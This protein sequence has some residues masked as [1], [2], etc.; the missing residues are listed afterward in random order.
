M[1]DGRRLWKHA[2][3]VAMVATVIVL[4]CYAMC[5]FGLRVFIGHR[6]TLQ[7]DQRIHAALSRSA[8]EPLRPVS[9]SPGGASSNGD[10][11][12]APVVLWYV[13][14]HGAVVNLTA[15]APILPHRR[16]SNIPVTM[17]IGATAFRFAAVRRDHG[18]VVAGQ[19]VSEVQRVDTALVLPEVLFGLLLCLATFVGSLLVAY[20]ASVP[21]ELVRRRQAEF[22]ADASHELR[23]PLSVVEAEVDLALRKPR[24]PEEYE[25]VLHRIAGESARLRRLVDDLLWLARAD[26]ITDG[27]RD[28]ETSDVA[29]VVASCVDRF[30]VVA[31]RDDLTLTFHSEGAGS[32]LVQASAELV[33]RLA[34]VLI[35]NAC[36]Y[37][38][39]GGAVSVTV[40]SR[41]GRV[42]LRVDDSGPG[43]P[44]QQRAAVFNRFHRIAPGGSG[45]GLGL[46]IADSVV[47]ITKGMWTLDEAPL[48]GARMEVSWP[49]LHLAGPPTDAGD[50]PPDT[51]QE[52]ARRPSTSAL[53]S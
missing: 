21:V 13:P 33:D 42:V 50:R 49:A 35:D 32:G 27:D 30:E 11:D 43:I 8:G 29:V 38:G 24:T 53:R 34:G 12:D 20:R 37:A 51:P 3:R 10:L 52:R 41:T 18:W 5:G 4:G 14:D 15:S 19:N 28:A 16:W 31:T 7:A 48:G 23:T 6:L 40:E 36:K 39:S 9:A 46:A 47:R 2:A 45:S 26:N 1:N 17:E 44:L 25:A 22:T